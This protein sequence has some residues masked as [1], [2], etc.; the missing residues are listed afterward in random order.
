MTTNTWSTFFWADWANDPDLKLCSLA[1][2]GLW[3]RMLTVCAMSSPRGYFVASGNKPPTPD[4]VVLLLGRPW[5]EVEPLIAELDRNHVFSRDRRSRIYNRR[6]VK[7]ALKASDNRENG[8]KGGNPTLRKGREISAA[9]NPPDKRLHT[10]TT[11][12]PIDSESVRSSVAPEVVNDPSGNHAAEGGS[13][14]RKRRGTRLP[15]G[16]TPSAAETAYAERHGIT[17]DRLAWLITEFLT[18]WTKGGGRNKTHLDWSQCFQNR[19]REIALRSPGNANG[20]SNGSNHDAALRGALLAI[21][22]L[23]GGPPSAGDI[24]PEPLRPRK[25]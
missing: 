12:L 8:K 23:G 6:M 13:T 10:T 15:K 21:N 7:D 16:W 11:S 24:E 22:D 5:S 14:E 4:E 3:M 17:G 9:D 25:D 1:A 18:Y 19:V 20:K 2:Q